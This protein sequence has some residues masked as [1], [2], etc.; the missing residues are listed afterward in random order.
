MSVSD[1][2]LLSIES[3]KSRL[4]PRVFLTFWISLSIVLHESV[5][6]SVFSSIPFLKSDKPLVCLSREVGGWGSVSLP[7][8]LT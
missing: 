7:H 8:F 1:R 6:I 4:T 3:K 5:L 2:P